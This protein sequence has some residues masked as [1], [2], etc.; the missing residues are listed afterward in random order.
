M[1]NEVLNIKSKI[2]LNCTICD[3]CCK[4]RGD[5]RLAP[6]SVLEICKYLKIE[7]KEFIN[8]YTIELEN[9][10]P[11]IVIKAVGEDRVCIFNDCKTYK[12]KIHKFRPIQCV[13]FPLYPV[14]IDR[15]LFINMG[16]CVAKQKKKTRIYK[17]LNEDKIYE[18]NK[19]SYI[20]WINLVEEIQPKW[21][22]YSIDVQQRIRKL[23]FLDYDLKQNLEK[24]IDNNMKKIREIIYN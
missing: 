20:K 9:E 17:W 24:Q 7:L 11:E 12:C 16:T 1:E 19:S 18:R 5:I 22:S 8:N 3:R 13:M 4:Y 15:D 23:I 14:D 6:I 2:P 21:N 10:P